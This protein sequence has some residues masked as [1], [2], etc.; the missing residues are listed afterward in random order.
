MYFERQKY[1]FFYNGNQTVLPLLKS[2]HFIFQPIWRM[3]CYKQTLWSCASTI[4]TPRR[5]TST[6]FVF[7]HLTSS[8]LVLSS[9]WACGWWWYGDDDGGCDG[10]DDLVIMMMMAMMIMIMPWLPLYI[11]VSCSSRC[12]GCAALSR[13]IASGSSWT[14][15]LANIHTSRI[16]LSY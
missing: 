15:V 16:P 14:G 1:V 6:F 3:E 7:F 8:T 9:R 12:W 10:D 13:S 4:W 5:S 2:K 11:W